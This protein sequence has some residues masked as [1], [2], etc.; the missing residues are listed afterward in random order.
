[1]Q[2][3]SQT[4]HEWDEAEPISEQTDVAEEIAADDE[5]TNEDTAPDVAQEEVPTDDGAAAQSE[6]LEQ[7]IS[8]LEQEVKE[9]DE[10]ILRIQA[11][12]DNFR[13]RSRIEKEELSKTA[14]IQLVE[15]LLPI[16]DNFERGLASSKQTQDLDSLVKGLEMIN[17]QLIQLLEKEEITAIEAV[18]KPFD[19]AYHQ[20]VM[21]VETDEHEEGTVVEE[22]QKGYI[23]KDRVIRPSMVKVSTSS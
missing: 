12:Y 1:M 3:D 4:K 14:A 5:Q 11:D 16:I 17:S 6:T 2:N 15:Q 7:K 20:A 13:R 9:K 18:G 23:Y 21:Q 8:A 10:R 19:P 22:L